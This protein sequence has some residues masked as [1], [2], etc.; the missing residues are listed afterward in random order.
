V[1]LSEQDV[2]AIFTSRL[3]LARLAKQYKV[4]KSTI[5]NIKQQRT[6]RHLT[7][8]ETQYKLE[9]SK[10]ELT[11]QHHREAALAY[12]QQARKVSE[13]DRRASESCSQVTAAVSEDS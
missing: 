7:D 11:K 6:Y 12:A 1:T 10:L 9:L 8:P 2:L 3:S 5:A 4:S 13:L